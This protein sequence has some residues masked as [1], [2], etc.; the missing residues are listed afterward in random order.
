MNIT[1]LFPPVWECDC[2][3][4]SLAYLAAF[5]KKHGHNVCT[6]DIN[7]ELHNMIFS[8]KTME[9]SVAELQRMISKS[10][11]G[12]KFKTLHTAVKFFETLG[13]DA[14]EMAISKLKTAADL[15]TIRSSQL[16]L[17][18][19]RFIFSAPYYPASFNSYSYI[20]P[21]E[22]NNTNSVLREIDNLDC[23]IFYKM[24]YSHVIEK[25]SRSD[26]VGISV[27]CV[28]QLIPSFTIAK[29]VKQKYKDKKVVVGGALMPYMY[30]AI[31][32]TPE[33]F[34]YV[35]CFIFGEGETPLLM[36]LEFLKD[37]VKIEEVPNILYSLS[38]KPTASQIKSYENMNELPTPDYSGFSWEQ[39][40]SPQRIITYLSSRGCPWDKCSF[41][42]LTSNYGQKYRVRDLDLVISD[43]LKLSKDI[44]SEVFMFNDESIPGK[45][46]EKMSQQ[47]LDRSLNLKWLCLSRLDNDISK[48]AFTLASKAGL[49]A[50]SYGLESGSQKMLDKINKGTIIEKVPQILKNSSESGIWNN[51][52]IFF[53]FPGEKNE[54]IE[55]TRRFINDNGQYIDTL[56]YGTFRLEGNSEIFK[57]PVKFGIDIDSFDEKFFGP[58]Y[59]Y[60]YMNSNPKPN[61]LIQSFE[62]DI[63]YRRFNGNNY[64]GIELKKI[65][66]LLTNSD[67]KSVYAQVDK[68]IG[69][70]SMSELILHD[71]NDNYIVDIYGKY[72]YFEVFN[73]NMGENTYVFLNPECGMSAELSRFC[74]EVLLYI[75][76]PKS[77]EDITNYFT[78][79]YN[80]PEL[81]MQEYLKQ[82]IHILC[83]L[84][85]LKLHRTNGEE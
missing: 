50:I 60:K 14:F 28:E 26:V 84:E 23:N 57:D 62:E 55:L 71:Y 70:K 15:E 17:E 81:T 27:T 66:L 5:L 35:D 21:T 22:I 30:E 4:P 1:L 3:Y 54:D 48:E 61:D 24:I 20:A 80:I 75:D 43:V 74:L 2:P 25:L 33:L 7:I 29:L 12:E 38:G 67:K 9:S 56:P 85:I 73:N 31:N 68:I 77:I 46:L 19:G 37:T 64:I 63:Q 58:Y 8:H 72:K 45:R 49:K 69:K 78:C 44:N 40:F 13:A 16:T 34:E 76:K 51:V 42:S 11:S 52:F 6:W 59:S 39:Y 41:C 47:F 82:I 32:N 36:W 83:K 18:I 10:S 65:L 53:G 79:K